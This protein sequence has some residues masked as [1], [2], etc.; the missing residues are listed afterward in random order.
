MELL[1]RG[2]EIDLLDENDVY[3]PAIVVAL[4]PL[5]INYLGWGE[6]WDEIL[7]EKDRHRIQFPG[8][9]YVK[10]CKAWVKYHKDACHWPSILYLRNPK[11]GSKLGSSYL[12]DETRVFVRPLGRVETTKYL[13]NYS[14]GVWINTSHVWPFHIVLEKRWTENG[15]DPK[16]QLIFQEALEAIHSPDLLD[17]NFKFNG[18]LDISSQKKTKNV[19]KVVPRN[20]KILN[21]NMLEIRK[22]IFAIV[23]PELVPL[24]QNNPPLVPQIGKISSESFE[25]RQ[26]HSLVERGLEIL[27]AT[28]AN[29][30]GEKKSKRKTSAPQ[31]I[32]IKRKKYT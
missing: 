1:Q 14:S 26:S 16:F 19:K 18:S 3:C 5:K 29:P 4:N 8:G 15:M 31:R 9:K 20:E 2:D 7:R 32:E 22:K 17:I 13:R 6:N 10:K 30:R 25:I 23:S 12:K 28:S 11:E 27:L 21:K 24:L